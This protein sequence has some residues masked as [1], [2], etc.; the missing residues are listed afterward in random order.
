MIEAMSPFSPL[1][2]RFLRGFLCL[3]I[4]LFSLLAGQ[5]PGNHA[6]SGRALPQSVALS[7]GATVEARLP[8]GESQRYLLHLPPESYAR[9]EVMQKG[10]AL[11]ATIYSSAGE[12]L[13]SDERRNR[14]HGPK[15]IHLVTGDGGAYYLEIQETERTSGPY[16]VTLAELRSA[17]GRDRRLVAAQSPFTEG[18]QLFLKNQRESYAAAIEKFQAAMAIYQEIDEPEGLAM[19]ATEIGGANE[20]LGRIKEAEEWN[21]RAVPMWRAVRNSLGEARALNNLGAMMMNQSRAR[22]AIEMYHQALPLWRAGGDPNGEARTLSNIGAAFDYLGEPQQA[23]AQYD[24][25]LKTWKRGGDPLGPPWALMS[26][27]LTYT[28]LGNYEWAVD[29]HQQAVALWRLNKSD[30]EVLGLNGLGEAHLNLSN[31]PQAIEEFSAA[32]DLRRRA[33]DERNLA[34]S[35]TNLATAFRLSGQNDQARAA[36]SE[37]LALARK[38][39]YPWVEAEALSHLG[40]LAAQ[41]SSPA[42][43]EKA[44]E[45]YRD[46]L[47]LSRRYGNYQNEAL[48]LYRLAQLELS[49]GRLDAARNWIE[50]A[51]TSYE[52]LR[53][54]VANQDLR[55]SFFATGQDYFEL[56]VD[57]LMQL[58]QQQPSAGYQ[59]LAWQAQERSRARSLLDLLAEARA[60]IRQDASPALLAQRQSLRQQLAEQTNRR[61]YLLSNKGANNEIAQADMAVNRLTEE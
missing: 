41:T 38:T 17:N 49:Q 8:A 59:R 45:L 13:A 23:L 61:L 14:L 26:I 47:A 44:Q 35:L 19:M 4:I 58:H 42:Q 5:Q 56:Y 39:V 12:R 60:D 29:C 28:T 3:G 36:Y 9:V 27:G 48:T 21:A 50:P 6:F 16:T 2:H 30:S 53:T 10:V 20:R 40:E 52:S 1:F 32:I 55:A 33:G 7:L 46:A 25:A 22:D 54:R 34:R 43:T 37:S 15:L 24:L 57:L 31:Y 11:S 18:R 51:L